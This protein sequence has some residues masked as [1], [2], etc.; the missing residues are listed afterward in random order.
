MG[1]PGVGPE[2][3]PARLPGLEAGGAPPSLSVTLYTLPDEVVAAMERVRMRQAARWGTRVCCRGREM[4]ASQG[5]SL[6]HGE[7]AQRIQ[8]RLAGTD[9]PRVEGRQNQRREGPASEAGAV[10]QA[11]AEASVVPYWSPCGCRMLLTVAQHL[12]GADQARRG[13]VPETRNCSPCGCRALPS[14]PV[15]G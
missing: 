10:P 15:R 3:D 1:D 14:S 8:S 13:V 2:A 11:L 9:Q 12:P 7:G 6:R 5:S 4:G